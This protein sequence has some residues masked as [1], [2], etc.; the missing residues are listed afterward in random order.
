M[1]K[2]FNKIV[3]F[4][5]SASRKAELAYQH[6]KDSGIGD[7]IVVAIDDAKP[8][9]FNSSVEAFILWTKTKTDDA[10]YDKAKSLLP[11]VIKYVGEA[12]GIIDSSRTLKDA[13]FIMF[14][15][16]ADMPEVGRGKWFRDI[17]GLV[18]KVFADG[19]LDSSDLTTFV[20]F[21]IDIFKRNR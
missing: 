20:F 19:K 4:F 1:K 10:I 17:S 8:F 21:M 14:G 11:D 7:K 9:I 6:L 16:I 15:K 3:S 13:L 18:A 2:L 5:L 12:D